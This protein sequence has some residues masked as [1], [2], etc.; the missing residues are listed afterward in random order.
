M[1]ILQLISSEGF[2]GAEN[3]LVALA[4]SLAASGHVVRVGVFH[5]ARGPHLE[6]AAAAR[7]EGL[8]TRVVPCRGRTDWRA[9]R[10][11][12]RE[13]ESSAI[14]LV[15]SH[16]YKADL[17]AR[18]ACL[19]GGPALVST[20]H[21]W[22]SQA[23]TMRAYAALDRLVLRS[24]DRVATP[25]PVV[26]DMLRRS[27]QTDNTLAWIQNGVDI[28]RFRT[29]EPA[30]QA[31]LGLTADTRVVG[32][33]GRLAPGKGADV[34]LHAA[35]QISATFSNVKFVVIGDGPLRIASEALA[36][37]LGLDGRVTFLGTRDD[38]PSVYASLDVLVLPS[39]DEAMPMCVLEAMAA[40]KPVIATRVGA[41]PNVVVAGETGYLVEPG[42]A[43]S[44]SRYLTALLDDHELADRLGASGYDRAAS[45]FSSEVMARKYLHL[46]E[47]ALA[48]R[49]AHRRT[50]A[51]VQDRG[52]RA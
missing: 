25:S 35:R 31:E 43:E 33:V 5:D 28:D 36:A 26:A 9:V 4:K 42:D 8:T 29:G 41:V 49:R 21:N 11:I 27:G 10:T 16:G 24:F 23:W 39:F 15:H 22:P 40:S 34:F 1:N 48:G 50:E 51:A 32:F 2:Y 3:M 47:A 19:P 38:M 14:D 46:Y 7:A 20:C 6:V 52:A 37:T 12:R 44:I 13:I 45:L 30:V 17:Y 18:A